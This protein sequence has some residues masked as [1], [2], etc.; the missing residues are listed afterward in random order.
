M[1]YND[2]IDLRE[3]TEAVKTKVLFF[4]EYY[5]CL[6]FLKLFKFAVNDLSLS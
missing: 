4:N 1:L 5:S 2:Q 6:V 3:L